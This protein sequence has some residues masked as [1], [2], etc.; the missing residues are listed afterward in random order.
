MWL[1]FKLGMIFINLGIPRRYVF[2]TRRLKNKMTGSL[3]DTYVEKLRNLIGNRWDEIWNV[4]NT[5]Q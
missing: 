3:S 2:H 4:V 5:R 1:D